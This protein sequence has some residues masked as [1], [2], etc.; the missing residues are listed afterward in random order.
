MY[1]TSESAKNARYALER[2]EAQERRRKEKWATV[3]RWTGRIGVALFVLLI[4]A[5]LMVKP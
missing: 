4:A 3:C 2:F 5:V 1:A